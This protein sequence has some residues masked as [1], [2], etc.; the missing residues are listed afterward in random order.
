MPPIDPFAR[1]TSSLTDNTSAKPRRGTMAPFEPGTE[2]RKFQRIPENVTIAVKTIAYPMTDDTAVEGIG[3][4]ISAG[5]ICFA[6][7]QAYE[8]GDLLSLQINLTGWQQHKSS[9]AAVID[10]ELAMAPLTAVARVAW[11]QARD[12]GQQHDIGV[13]FENIYDDDFQALKRYLLLDTPA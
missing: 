5:G 9:V 8:P 11:C 4:N 6:V 3:K 2:K 10:D 1:R 7:S 13:T 12:D